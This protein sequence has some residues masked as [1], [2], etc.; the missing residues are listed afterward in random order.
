MKGR[1]APPPLSP[2]KSKPTLEEAGEAADFAIAA[3]TIAKKAA[4]S[5]P[6][7]DPL[8]AIKEKSAEIRASDHVADLER[9]SGPETSFLARISPRHRNRWPKLL[10]FEQRLV[11]F[12]RR[13]EVLR[14]E[15]AELRQ[16]RE[17]APERH[18]LALA[19]WF[20]RGENGERPGS[21]ADVLEQAIVM[22]DAE[23]VAVDRLVAKLLDE[24]ITYVT[25]NRASLRRTAEGATAKARATYEQ[26]IDAL[27]G[28]REELLDC[29][30]DQVWAEL[31]PSETTRQSRGTEA[32]LSLG[33]QAP[34]KRT[35]GITNQISITA[36]Y[37]A[38]TADAA[39]IVERLTPEQ[40]KELGFRPQATPE[41][42]AMW[43]EDPRYKE[44]AVAKQREL[45]ERAP[46][47][48]GS[49]QLRNMAE[50]MRDE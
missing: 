14:A 32:N 5:I 38:L 15:L 24:K 22:K 47:A 40:R 12:D 8:Q 43:R 23:V 41:T 10:E 2:Q 25:K 20:E 29:R 4:E 33:L 1:Q 45:N 39:S 27:A 11:E 26:A 30:S 13:Q 48:T 6:K 34:V 46:W 17:T 18:A 37:E 21:D 7:S 35:L 9:L 28:A 49:A 42:E 16:Q 36:I 3:A 44:W 31:Y 50:E 19:G